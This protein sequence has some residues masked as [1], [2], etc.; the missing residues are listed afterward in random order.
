MPVLARNVV[1][2]SQPLATQAG[3]EMLRRGGNAADAALAAAITLCVVEPT[4]NGIG[5]DAFAIIWDGSGLHALNGS[6][7]SPRAWSRERFAGLAA[8][9]TAG[10]DAV[11]V[12]GAVD[13]WVSLSRRFGRLPFSALFQPAIA[14]ARDGY[15]VSPIIARRWQE[16]QAFC[17]G[18]AEL[19]A[20]FFPSGK[21]PRAGG[22]F[23]CAPQAESL[24]AIA[25]SGGESFYRG[26]LADRIADCAAADRGALSREDLAAHRSDWVAPLS[27]NYRG[28]F[29]HEIPPNGQG[30]AALIALGV[31]RHFDPQA[32]APDSADGIHLQIEAMKSAFADVFA[33]VAD[34]DHMQLAPEALLAE[35]RL[36]AKARRIRPDRAGPP[37]SGARAAGGTVYLAAADEAGM[38]VSYI[39]SNY[40]GFGSG[41]VVPGTG[42]AL[43]NRGAGFVLERDHPNCVGGAKRPFHTIIPAFVTR[44]GRSLMS[45]G[46]MGALMQPQGHVQMMVRLF[47]HGQN[48]QS[49][50]DAPRWHVAPDAGVALE[51]GFPP[52]V[53]DGLR[54]KGHR[55]VIEPDTPLFGGAQLV[56]RLEETYAA[57]SDPRKDGQAAGY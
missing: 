9:P 24:A 14:Y 54:R 13:A 26:A 57:A 48:P 51:P 47:D 32:T 28:A 8:M 18:F 42:I 21:P 50:C 37:V 5:S 3:L 15:P 34:I 6:G 20:T 53:A 46:V 23:R 29:L 11:T 22:L 38:M 44:D 43:Q 39:Q 25:E 2:T 33:H 31:L 16:A 7:R 55:V 36:A 30:L 41:V 35:D 1:A 19:S 56:Y 45:F 4:G 10:W 49:A 40:M 27:V 17:N 52:A 12:P